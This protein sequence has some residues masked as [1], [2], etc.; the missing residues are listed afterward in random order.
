MAIF[1][2]AKRASEQIAT[3]PSSARSGRRPWVPLTMVGSKHPRGRAAGRRRHLPCLGKMYS[4]RGPSGREYLGGGPVDP[5]AAARPTT[6]SPARPRRWPRS[7]RCSARVRSVPA[8]VSLSSRAMELR[9]RWGL[10]TG[11]GKRIGRSI[12]LAL[13]GRGLNVIVHYNASADAAAATVREIEALGVRAL[14]LRADLA[15]GNDVARLARE[16]EARSGGVDVLVNNAS[17]YLRAPFDEL[18]EAIWDASLDVNLKA[19]FFL[20]WHLG[21]AMRTRGRGRIVNLADWAGERPYADYLPYCV[22]KAGVICLTKALAKALAPAVQVNAV[23]PGP[24]A[25]PEDL[26]AAEREA[27]VRATPL[28]RFGVPE[29]V[30]R[31]VRF[32]VEEADF[33]TGAVYLVDGGRLVA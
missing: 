27:I 16:A 31:C 5:T 4:R 33:T 32:L 2:R 26:T 1:S 24:V 3:G 10:V 11:A 18:T 7:A 19:P 17:N 15:R 20:A 12:A 25:L 29:D 13:A 6:C 8:G 23:S 30:A 14:A 9:G 21:R 22:S 28:R